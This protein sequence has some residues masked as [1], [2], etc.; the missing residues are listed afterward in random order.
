[1][2]RVYPSRRKGFRVTCFRERGE[3]DSQGGHEQ[4]SDDEEEDVHHHVNV[5]GVRLEAPYLRANYAKEP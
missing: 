2:L 4:R 5:E 1:M 3:K